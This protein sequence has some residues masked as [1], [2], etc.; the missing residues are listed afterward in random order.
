[1]WE[2]CGFFFSFFVWFC[3]L[4][5]WFICFFLGEEF[6]EFICVC[7]L[8]QWGGR[9][10]ERRGEKGIYGFPFFSFGGQFRVF[11]DSVC[12]WKRT[13]G[14]CGGRTT[15]LF[16]FLFSASERE[17]EKEEYVLVRK[18]EKSQLRNDWDSSWLFMRYKWSI[19]LY[20]TSSPPAIDYSRQFFFYCLHYF[21]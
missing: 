1:M 9:F 4:F 18:R 5:G 21:T 2:I 17:R 10:V 12:A 6:L 7:E 20:E 3:W 8:L 19:I 16:L 11:G 15:F 13:G 14:V